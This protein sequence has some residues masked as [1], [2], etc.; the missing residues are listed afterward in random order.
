M[1]AEVRDYLERPSTWLA[2]SVLLLPFGSAANATSQLVTPADLALLTAVAAAVLEVLRGR[3]MEL[4]R[5][6]PA[7]AFL[8]LGLTTSTIAL[9]A[10]DARLGLVGAVRFMELFFL[11]PITFLIALRTHWDAV[12]LVGSLELLAVVEGTVG[13]AQRVTRTGAEIDGET[14][15]AVGTFGA[16]NI[17]ALA[18]LTALATVIALAWGM[19]LTG[20]I[21]WLCFALAGYLSVP[22]VLSLSRGVWVATAAGAFVVLTRGR[23]GRMLAGFAAAA[24]AGA[25]VLPPLIAGQSSLGERVQSLIS[26]GSD[27]DQSVKDRLALWGAA[28]AMTSEH[29]V[30]GIGPRAFPERRDAYADLTLLGSSDISDA[31]GFRQVELRSPHNFFLLVASEQ[32]M[33]A[34]T[35]YVT[36]LAMLLARSLIRAARRESGLS[37]AMTMSGAGMLAY[38][39]VDMMSGD[40]GGPNSVMVAMVLGMAG[41][42]AA[43]QPLQKDYRMLWLERVR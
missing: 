5:S 38:E 1:N 43:D 11:V 31:S 41:W 24:L 14:I 26:A 3:R 9:L 7:L 17:A 15:R 13:I 22:M 33:L 36:V 23:P 34:L 39:L 18:T 27:P 40:L 16:Y 10:V 30:V 29:P 12:V 21:R 25:L 8:L 4:A 37:M 6:L 20:R 19:A 42:A 35:V 28:G 32:G 2:I